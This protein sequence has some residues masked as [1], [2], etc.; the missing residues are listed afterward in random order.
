MR[1]VT[2]K[3]NLTYEE[4]LTVTSEI[5]ALLNSR[6][7]S[8]V[9]FDPNDPVALTP[10]PFFIENIMLSMH[11][12]DTRALD[13]STR[14][15]PTQIIREV[16]WK[17]WK[18]NYIAELQIRKNC[19]LSGA[20]IMV[21]RL[22][23]LVEGKTKSQS[24]I[25]DS[26]TETFTGNFCSFAKNEHTDCALMRPVVKVR[27]EPV[28]SRVG[29]APSISGE[30]DQAKWKPHIPKNCD[31]SSFQLHQS[32]SPVAQTEIWATF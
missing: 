12:E 27:K 7:L 29:S 16:F 20:D 22:A 8:H 1:R 14:Y 31:S 25:T 3:Q 15:R 17:A 32:D 2:A 21:G 4:F 9:S 19:F 5:E 18:G 11:C 26:V 6:Q 13:A 10:S 30:V 28:N 23:L 24:T